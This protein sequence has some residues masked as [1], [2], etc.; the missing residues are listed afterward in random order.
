MTADFVGIGEASR[1]LGLSRTSLQK[2]VDS[3]QLAAVKTA[4]G[5]RRLPREAVEAINRKMGPKAL[6]RLRAPHPDAVFAPAA[7]AAQGS[8]VLTVLVVEDDAPTAALLSGFFTHFY[9]GVTCLMATDGLD[10]VLILERSRPRILITDLNMQPFDGFRLLQLVSG[11]PEYQSV[12][13]VVVSGMG[14]EEINRRGGLA[15]HVLF[16]RKPLN[17]DRLRGLVDAHVQLFN[18]TRCIP[19]ICGQDTFT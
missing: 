18:Q 10:A 4:G 11:R 9:P 3:G 2:L 7:M 17:L 1:I 19:G 13:L 12:A 6:L 5:H 16:L 8:D 15:P 14:D